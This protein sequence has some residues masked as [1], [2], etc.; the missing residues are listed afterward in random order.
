M[1]KKTK[2]KCKLECPHCHAEWA[3]FSYGPKGEVYPKDVIILLG[4]KKKFKDGDELRC[5]ICDHP[6]TTWDLFLA[7]GEGTLKK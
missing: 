4:T 6:H 5:S 7:I 2:T 1:P 3:E